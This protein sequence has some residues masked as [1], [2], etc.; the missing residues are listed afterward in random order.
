MPS[1]DNR[2]SS[3]YPVLLNNKHS[4]EPCKSI[5]AIYLRST[6]PVHYLLFVVLFSKVN[7]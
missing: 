3:V 2:K 4:Q 6:G 1:S 7:K 5:S